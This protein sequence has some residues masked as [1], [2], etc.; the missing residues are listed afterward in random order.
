MA[1]N[2]VQFSESLEVDTDEQK[3]WLEA[4]LKQWTE[5]MTPGEL[6]AWA[7]ERDIEPDDADCWPAFDYAFEGTSTTKELEKARKDEKYVPTRT[8]PWHL[9]VHT[10]ESG[11]PDNVASMVA[12][13]FK[14]FK[15]DSTFT[16]T[17]SEVCSKPRLGEFSGGGF[18]VMPFG[19]KVL[20]SNPYMLF[21]KVHAKLKAK[22]AA[23]K[24]GKR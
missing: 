24:K 12:A 11:S 3:A 16:L 8:A 18:I 2:Y 15:I 1:N 22:K 10:D 5:E 4:W 14:K 23:A 6:E 17:W 21:D 9:W 13:F 20:W 19:K 7:K